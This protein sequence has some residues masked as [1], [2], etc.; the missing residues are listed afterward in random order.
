MF[1]Q[2]L[3]KFLQRILSRDFLHV[4]SVPVLRMSAAVLQLVATMWITRQLPQTSGDFLFWSAVLMTLGQCAAF[5]LDGLI[6]QQIPRLKSGEVIA[7]YLAPIRILV[8][9]FSVL[10]GL[11]LI[12]YARFVQANPEHTLLW[13]LLLPVCLAGI[14]LCRI[15][16]E[17]MKGMAFPH[18]A[19]LYRQLF[20]A[21]LFLAGMIFLG[22]RLTSNNALICYTIAFGVTGFGGPWGPGFS[23]LKP[24]Y[25]FPQLENSLSH[26]R[27][28]FP[29]FLAATFISLEYVVPLTI[30]ENTHDS[31]Q[32]A[33]GTTAY[34]MFMIFDLLAL[35]VHSVAMPRL[36]RSGH[37]QEWTEMTKIY[38]STVRNGLMILAAPLLF[39]ILFATPLMAALFGP[40]F[41]EAGPILSIFL[42]FTAVSLCLGPASELILMT[43]DSG[44]VATF[45]FVQMA[46]T[47]II[48]LALVPSMASKGLALGIGSGLIVSKLLCLRHF[49]TRHDKRFAHETKV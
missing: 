12:A 21:A 23:G 30:L 49:F 39:G 28:G 6:L 15:N 22:G 16:G 31:Q 4:A 45:S 43:G 34:R 48:S 18:H 46:F 38:G 25:S 42:A 20:A 1:R 26:I 33:F 9:G 47:V 29:I 40:Q 10:L 35:S 5:G 17:A 14:A 24:R 44:K 2:L 27:S 41:S 11:G 13:Y 36:S 37:S 8:A 32:V 3:S 7:N 19:I